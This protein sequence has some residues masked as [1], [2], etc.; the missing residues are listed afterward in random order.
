MVYKMYVK[1]WSSQTQVIQI[2]GWVVIKD[3]GNGNIEMRR[4]I[5][6][7]KYDSKI[8]NNDGIAIE[9]TKRVKV[10]QFPHRS[11]EYLK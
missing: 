1:K 10:G 6:T 4:G 8:Q 2:W 3:D 5:G 9:T 7:T 11:S